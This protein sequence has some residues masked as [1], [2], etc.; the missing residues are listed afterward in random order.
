MTRVRNDL[1]D[2]TKG[3][4]RGRAGWIEA[5]W[6]LVKCAFFL[7]AFPWPSG[8]K[9]SLLRIFGAQIGVGVVIKPRVNIHLPWKLA[10]GNHTWIG[11]EVFILNMEPVQIGAARATQQQGA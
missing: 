1:F 8:L 7:S 3:L 9:R 4:E 2:S 5:V 11:E 6:Y 10:I